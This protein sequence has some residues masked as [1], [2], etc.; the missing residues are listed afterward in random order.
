MDQGW[1]KPV[2]IS[3]GGPPI[4]HLC[5]ADDLFIFAEA[6]MDQVEIIK[7]CLETFANSSGQ[8]ISKEKTK[9]FFSNNVH[10]SRTTEIAEAFGFGLTGDLGKYLGVPLRHTRTSSKSFSF[11]T[12][13]LLQR[14]NS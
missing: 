4:T 6:C 7:N 11:V 10:F 5:F 12:D 13:K 2:S 3:R 9:I 1:W 8:K 14:M